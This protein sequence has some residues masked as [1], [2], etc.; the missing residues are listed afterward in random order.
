MKA[1]KIMTWFMLVSC[2]ILLA[3]SAIVQAKRYRVK[4]HTRHYKNGKVVR[5]GSH[6]RTSKNN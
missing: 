5:I 6:T 3:F 1:V 2:A 4:T